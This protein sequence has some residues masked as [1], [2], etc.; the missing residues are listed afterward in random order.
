MIVIIKRFSDYKIILHIPEWFIHERNAIQI[1]EKEIIINIFIDT[2]LFFY[3]KKINRTKTDFFMD[4]YNG[5]CWDLFSFRKY[6]EF[7][8]RYFN[9][10][11]QV[12]IR[13]NYRIRKILYSQVV[14]QLS[15]SLWE[16][17]PNCVPPLAVKWG[18]FI[19]VQ[20]NIILHY[21]FG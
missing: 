17:Q 7:L 11:I 12:P 14:W 10:I 6:Q 21:Y 4:I 15:R 9:V 8:A 3:S 1:N 2:L 5:K 13:Y 20:K 16:Q 19:S 18:T